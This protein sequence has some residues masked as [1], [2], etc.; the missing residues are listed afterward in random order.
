MFNG[1]FRTY[2]SDWVNYVWNEEYSFHHAVHPFDYVFPKVHMPI[3]VWKFQDFC[4]TQILREINFVDSKIT[5]TA[6]FAI[7][8]AVDFVHL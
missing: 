3:T 6:I 1:K 8:G 7:L 5:K 2:G 4:I